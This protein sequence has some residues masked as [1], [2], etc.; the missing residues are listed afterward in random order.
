MTGRD[1]IRV[2]VAGLGAYGM[3]YVSCLRDIGA[4]V[5]VEVKAVADRE[6][7][8]SAQVAR[9]YGVER[10]YGDAEALAKDPELD[11]VCVVTSEDEHAR[12][13]LIAL[14]TGKHVIVEKPLALRVEDVDSLAATAERHGRQLMVGYQLRSCAPYVEVAARLHSGELG[15]LIAL[16][17]RR[18]RPG[19][20]MRRY[21]RVHPFW[22]TGVHDVDLMI[23]LARSS[24][25][26]VRAWSRTVVPGPS[27]DAVWAMLEFES[28]V[29]G[30]IESIWLAPESPG[31]Y[32]DDGLSVTGRDGVARVDFAQSPVTVWNRRGY[33]IPDV[34]Y[35]PREPGDSV[36]GALRD[37]LVHLIGRLRGSGTPERPPIAEVRHGVAVVTAM[38]E[39]AETGG[40]VA[41]DRMQ[42]AP[43]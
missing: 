40:V 16:R 34:F 9:R 29:V 39:A 27:P 32:T 36:G 33:S 20:P 31:L 15:P 30:W 13:A 19:A 42:P 6:A 18:N 1:T 8:H 11:L 23:W 5:G 24:V 38:V 43:R 25:R 35:E 7:G 26:S 41:V 4:A 17:A 22:E 37:H 12:P 3:A 28:G 2:G 10:N 21:R 14:E